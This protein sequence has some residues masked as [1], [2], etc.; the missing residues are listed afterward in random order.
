VPLAASALEAKLLALFTTKPLPAN[1]AEAGQKWAAAYAEYAGV[2]T[3]G[4]AV[5][6]PA[7]LSAAEVS[8]GDKLKTAFETATAAGPA[9]LATVTA[10]MAIAFSNFW[11]V[12]PVA[13]AAPGVTGAVTA[14]LPATLAAELASAFT[15]EQSATA[16]AQAARIAGVVHTWTLTVTVTNATAGGP[17]IVTLL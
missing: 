5:P 10:A 11:F 6:S 4:G 15:A 7:S 14:A 17:V 12:P 8:L 13:F 9:G 16:A 1:A 3:A 2:A